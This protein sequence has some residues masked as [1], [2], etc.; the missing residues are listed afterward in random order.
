[1]SGDEAPM[2][3]R[4]NDALLALERLTGVAAPHKRNI[5]A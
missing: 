4:V 5:T 1:M 3:Q 2:L